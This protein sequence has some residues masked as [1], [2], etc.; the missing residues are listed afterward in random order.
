[1]VARGMLRIPEDAFTPTFARWK[2]N[3]VD[4][5]WKKLGFPASADGA[6]PAGE[7]AGGEAAAYMVIGNQL[8]RA[9]VT[10]EQVENI[11]NRIAYNRRFYTNSYAADTTALMDIDPSLQKLLG[12]LMRHY[13]EVWRKGVDF[14]YARQTGLP[15]PRLSPEEVAQWGLPTNEMN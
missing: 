2:A 4:G 9:G 10:P 12:S 14:M 3:N 5:L 8:R 7:T 1:R 11:F 6:L 15:P 13:P